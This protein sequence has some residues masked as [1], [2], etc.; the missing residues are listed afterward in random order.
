MFLKFLIASDVAAHIGHGIL[1]DWTYGNKSVAQSLPSNSVMSSACA[2]GWEW[3]LTPGWV[4]CE[5][6]CFAVRLC[7]HTLSLSL[8]HTHSTGMYLHAWKLEMAAADTEKGKEKEKEKERDFEQKGELARGNTATD[9]KTANT[10]PFTL[11]CIATDYI[12]VLIPL[13]MWGNS[14]ICVLILPQNFPYTACNTANTP[15]STGRSTPPVSF[16]PH[17]TMCPQTTVC[18]LMLLYVCRHTTMYVFWY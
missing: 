9:C 18:V 5:T 10:P 13:Y 16:A 3:R 14:Y 2:C 8:S 12:C 17:S 4:E 6:P 7:L 1:G 11:R 15:A